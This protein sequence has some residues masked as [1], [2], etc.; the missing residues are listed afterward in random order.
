MTDASKLV[1]LALQGVALSAK[2]LARRMKL[3]DSALRRYGYG[4]RTVRPPV[5]KRLAR[6]LR[7]HARHLQRVSAALA[8]LAAKQEKAWRLQSGTGGR[9]PRKRRR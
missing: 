6:L 7:E 5:M 8:E 2:A 4:D 3:S 9:R 1:T